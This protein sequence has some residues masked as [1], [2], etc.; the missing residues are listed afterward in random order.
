[1]QRDP[2]TKNKNKRG[3]NKKQENHPIIYIYPTMPLRPNLIL[4][5]NFV[6]E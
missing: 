3:K 6:D 1:M 5:E 2:M 4:E